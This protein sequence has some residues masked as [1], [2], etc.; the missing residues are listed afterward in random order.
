DPGTFDVYCKLVAGQSTEIASFVIEDDVTPVDTEAPSAPTEVDGQ[1]SDF[2]PTSINVRWGAST[3]NVGVTEYIIRYEGEEVRVP[4]AAGPQLSKLIEGLGPDSEYLFEISAVDA[5]GNESDPL[6]ILLVTAAPNLAPSQV[7]GV[8]ATPALNSVALSWAA[9]TDAD[10]SVA[11]YNVYNGATKVAT[12]TGTTAT[13]SGLAVDTA[14]SFQVEAV[15]NKGL[16]GAKSTVVNTRTLKPADTTAPT[17][18][19]VTGTATKTAVT[20]NW[21]GATDNV[22]VVGYDVFNGT[23]ALP[24]VT[25][26]TTTVSGLTPDTSY[27]FKVVAKDAAGNKSTGGTVTVKTLADGGTGPLPVKYSYALKGSTN[28]NTLS[29][30][31]LPLVGGINAELTLA[32]G[33]FS[34]DLTLNDT[35]GRLTALGFLPVTAKIGFVP[36]GKTTGTLLDGV[37][38]TKSFIRIKVK[39]VKLF[40]A[41]PLAGGNNCQTKSLS[42]INLASAANAEFK[43]L[44]GGAISGTYRISDLNGCGA[45]NGLVSP[46]TAGAGNTINAVL[47]PRPVTF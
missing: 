36:S 25:G 10:G 5:A 37:L 33:A 6:V 47:T 3:D 4:A 38:K 39:E 30:G 17:N 16:A 40:G 43:P 24:S 7:S 1:I 41:I 35:Q 26:T 12:V 34:A 15:D 18:P 44:T 14:Y 2:G 23:T 8:T 32:T 31:A 9:A 11:S 27:T 22:G 46:L 20:L 13:V 21:S 28:V 45:L 19:T 29:K 42:E